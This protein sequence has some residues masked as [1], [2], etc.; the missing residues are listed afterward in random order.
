[1]SMTSPW[2]RVLTAGLNCQFGG[3]VLDLEESLSLENADRGW[4]NVVL[5]R[6][7]R[8]DLMSRNCCWQVFRCL[9][10]WLFFFSSLFL[11]SL[12][13]ETWWFHVWG[14]S[15]QLQIQPP[16]PSFTLQLFSEHVL[17][18]KKCYEVGILWRTRQTGR[19]PHGAYILEQELANY[20]LQ[21]KSVPRHRPVRPNSQEWFLCF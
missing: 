1:M 13:S 7:R 11:S 9:S 4:S 8:M 15:D 18:P 3:F 17:C 16:Q 5:A 21:A 2:V 12:F 6:D 20:S 19:W 14:T 10:L